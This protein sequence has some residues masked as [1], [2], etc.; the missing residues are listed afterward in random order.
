V[1]ISQIESTEVVYV[2][3]TKGGLRI[4]LNDHHYMHHFTKQGLIYY[5]CIIFDITQCDARLVMKDSRVYPI[6]EDHNHTYKAKIG[7]EATKK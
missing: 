7:I 1:D 6:N 3:T 2:P 4:S 5:R